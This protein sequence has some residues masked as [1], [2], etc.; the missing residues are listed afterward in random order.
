MAKRILIAQGVL[1]GIVLAVIA[2]RELPGAV[3]ELKMWRMAR[4]RKPTSRSR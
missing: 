2:L 4:L 1:V 3:R